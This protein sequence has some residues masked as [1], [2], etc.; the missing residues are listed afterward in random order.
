[1]V[2][3]A[4]NPLPQSLVV[5]LT[6][7][8]NGAAA[9]VSLAHDPPA[10]AVRTVHAM[11]TAAPR[12]ASAVVRFLV[13]PGI[14]TPLCRSRGAIV[15]ERSQNHRSEAPAKREGLDTERTAP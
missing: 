10:A 12:A 13:L 3:S 7:Q 15:W 9:L 14:G 4:P 8:A 1:M 6:R 5:Y 2:T 11:D